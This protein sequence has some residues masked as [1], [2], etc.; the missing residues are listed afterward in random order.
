MAGFRFPMGSDGAAVRPSPRWNFSSPDLDGAAS[1]PSYGKFGY[2]G[3]EL[4]SGR[5]QRFTLGIVEPTKG[6]TLH[7]Y[8]EMRYVQ[9][10]CILLCT[11]AKLFSV[12]HLAFPVLS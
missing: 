11:K 12:V 5:S 4:G 10:D 1:R 6:R 9:T 3:M 8:K 7:V 2:V